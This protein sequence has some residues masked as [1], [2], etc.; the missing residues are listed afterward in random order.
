MSVQ[1]GY[2]LLRLAIGECGIVAVDFAVASLPEQ[3]SPLSKSV[4]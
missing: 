3:L 1:I 2:G 4:R